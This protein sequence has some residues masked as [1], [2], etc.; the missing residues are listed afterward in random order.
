[1]AAVRLSLSAKPLH[2]AEITVNKRLMSGT[3]ARRQRARA[4]Y[5]AAV[6]RS[7]RGGV[8]RG[9]DADLVGWPGPITLTSVPIFTR[10]YR[11]IASSFVMRMHPE[12]MACPMYS[13]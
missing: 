3:V 9:N 7:E 6:N 13:G 2:Y 10:L 8:G 11:S 5:L 12:E 1:M 4:L